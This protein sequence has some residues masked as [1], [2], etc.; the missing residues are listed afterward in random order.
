MAQKLP[1][2][3]NASRVYCSSSYLVEMLNKKNRGKV[4]FRS[5]CLGHEGNGIGTCDPIDCQ[6]G[7][8]WPAGSVRVSSFP[9]HSM[10]FRITVEIDQKRIK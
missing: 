4:Y 6:D 1:I 9:Y 10:P 5:L 3:S 8:C 2:L 7:F